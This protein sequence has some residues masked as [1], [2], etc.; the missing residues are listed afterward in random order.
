MVV[1]AATAVIDVVVVII[2]IVFY[3]TNLA[4]LLFGSW[5]AAVVLML[6]GAGL[7]RGGGAWL[8]GVVPDMLREG[9]P[10]TPE[11]MAAAA[12]V[13]FG[14]HG[15]Q[16]GGASL[17]FAWE[18]MLENLAYTCTYGRKNCLT[19]KIYGSGPLTLGKIVGPVAGKLSEG[20]V[21]C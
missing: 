5:R 8:H 1:A 18:L 7:A 12:P 17:S 2:A 20:V 9:K 21:R 6:V 15:V 10:P 13:L 14:P 11:Q 16:N 4:F 3:H 19:D